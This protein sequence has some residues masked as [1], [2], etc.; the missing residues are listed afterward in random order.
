MSPANPPINERIFFKNKLFKLRQFKLFRSL[1]EY[2]MA[3]KT[4]QFDQSGMPE[5][6]KGEKAT[7][8]ICDSGEYVIF[9]LVSMQP[10]FR[11]LFSLSRTQNR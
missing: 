4:R 10:E 11:G 3:L 1:R 6:G 2:P 8:H 5:K 7:D 9:R